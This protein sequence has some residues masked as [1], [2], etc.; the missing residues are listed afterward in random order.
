MFMPLGIRQI[1]QIVRIQLTALV[2]KLKRSGLDVSFDEAAIRFLS[3]KGYVPEYGA[4][5][6]KRVINDLFVNDLT[7]KLLEK[8]LD[9]ERKILVTLD[10]EKLN[11]INT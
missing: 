3:A 10:G 4:R 6:V 7:M 5:P 9:K 2:G 1:E 8:E 11:F